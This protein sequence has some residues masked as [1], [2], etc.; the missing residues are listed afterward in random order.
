[1][2]RHG[3]QGWAYPAIV[4]SGPNGNQWHYESSGRQ[5]KDGDLVVMDYGGS[6][7][8]LTMDITRT[9]PVNGRFTDAQRKAERASAGFAAIRE[10]LGS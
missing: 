2:I 5:T 4:A 9:W 8:H 3:M 6:L 1:M 10:L 7:D